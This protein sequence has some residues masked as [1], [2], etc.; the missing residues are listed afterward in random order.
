MKNGLIN[1]ICLLII[2]IGSG[3]F[4]EGYADVPCFKFQNK[5]ELNLMFSKYSNLSPKQLNKTEKRV[6]HAP[7]QNIT[8]C[9]FELSQEVNKIKGEPKKWINWPKYWYFYF[10]H[11][12]LS[13]FSSLVISRDY[14]FFNKL[15]KHE[16]QSLLQF[17]SGFC[18]RDIY[19]GFH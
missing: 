19:G 18:N 16:Y 9:K 14:L 15:W 17:L 2:K 12:I 1:K 7:K 5:F 8:I 4:G 13:V 10:L 3:F 6:W 11:F